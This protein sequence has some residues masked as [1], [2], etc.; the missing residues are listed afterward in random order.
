M[1]NIADYS[2]Q[3]AANG[4]V[5]RH[6]DRP[7]PHYSL[8]KAIHNFRLLMKNKDDTSLVFKIY[9]ALPSGK[10]MP[11]VQNLCQ[12]E[13]GEF[14]HQSE[15]NLPE[16]LDDHAAL[17]R[18]PA[19]SLAHAYCDFMESEGLTAAGLVADAESLGLPKYDDMAQWFGDRSRDLHD[20][21]HV[22]TG[23]GRDAL[24]EQC[25]LLFTNGQSPSQ[26]HLLIGYAGSLNI[27][28]QMKGSKAPVMGAANQASRTG[29]GSPRLIEQPVRE[30]L[31]QPID[32]LRE[33]LNI[34]DPTIYRQC[35]EIWQAE[36]VDPYNLL[37][38]EEQSGE[39]VSA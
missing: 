11:R 39:L 20:L 7:Q 1:R 29:K 35:H 38:G 12:S 31:K 18:T 5:L 4:T 16:I 10:F 3:Y 21:F 36:G 23:Y 28:L 32:S 19:G 33:A 30:L 8:P 22:L 17:R 34:P 6:P 24:G 15:P 25:V 27:K 2:R 14:L 13:L 9:D 26:G 37:A